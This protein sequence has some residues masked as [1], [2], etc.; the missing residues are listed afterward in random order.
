MQKA[1][2]SIVNYLTHRL[3]PYQV[4]PFRARVDLGAM[5]MKGYSAFTKQQHYWNL[6]KR[7]PV[8]ISGTLLRG[9]LTSLQ[10]SSRCILQPQPTGQVCERVRGV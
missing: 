8:I 7:L 5:A 4:L 9:S 1:V 6:T 3:D 10:R 2:N